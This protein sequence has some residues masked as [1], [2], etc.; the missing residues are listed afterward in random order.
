MTEKV[1]PGIRRVYPKDDFPDLAVYCQSD[2]A[3]GHGTIAERAALDKSFKE[4]FGIEIIWQAANSPDTNALDLG[5]WR[6]MSAKV[7]ALNAKNRDNVDVLWNTVLEAYNEWGKLGEGGESVITRV[8]D[9]LDVIA[10]YIIASGGDNAHEHARAA[11]V[12]VGAIH[13]ATA[14]VGG[15]DE[16]DAGSGEDE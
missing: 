1:A 12:R 2:N 5:L 16:E 8:Y 7:D 14:D 4:G 10:D 3:G 13:D 9:K 6:S 11:G 15:S